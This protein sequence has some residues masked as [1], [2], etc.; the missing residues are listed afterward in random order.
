MLLATAPKRR[1]DLVPFQRVLY[2]HDKFT[3]VFANQGEIGML[4]AVFLLIGEL[5]RNPHSERM[6]MLPSKQKFF[7]LFESTCIYPDKMGC[8]STPA[9]SIW[10]ISAV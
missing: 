6:V 9:S 4:S 1:C 2:L 8:G 5:N 10:L 3:R 7:Q